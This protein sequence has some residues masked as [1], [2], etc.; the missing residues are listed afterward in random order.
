V[1]LRRG[2]KA[3]AE[4][5]AVRLREQLGLGPADRIE[6]T[7]I[8]EHLDVKVVSADRLVERA[9]L[10]ELERIQSFAFS[11]A[12]FEI[13]GRNIIVTNPIRTPGRLAS[14]VA[15]EVSHILL[16]HHLSEIREVD[17]LPF[18]TCKP[19]EEEQATA[20]GGTLLLPRPL[21]V[22]AARN[23]LGPEEIAAT[24]GVTVEM[25]RYRFN[26]TGVAKQVRARSG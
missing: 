8:A 10:E 12:T 11:A 3:E 18:R 20:L 4:R 23:S 13:G 17:G 16:E 5:R 25:A 7:D 26:T 6:V 19:D 21:L 14:D 24:Y 22:Q 1:T 2:F 9:R 15:H